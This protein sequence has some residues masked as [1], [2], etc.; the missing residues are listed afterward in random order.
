[1]P[2]SRCHWPATLR[3]RVDGTAREELLT[4]DQVEQGHWLA[5]QGMDDV[6][7]IDHVAV[8]AVG[9]RPPAAQRHQRRRAEKTFEPIVVKTHA[10]AM[11]DQPAGCSWRVCRMRRFAARAAR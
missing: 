6:P 4:I 5:A 10:Q 7:V 9:M 2:A 11:A 8:L 1:M 3:R